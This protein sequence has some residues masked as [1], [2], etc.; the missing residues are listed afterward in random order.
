VGHCHIIFD[1][2]A[3]AFVLLLLVCDFD[4]KL[5]NSVWFIASRGVVGRERVGTAFPHLFHDFIKYCFKVSLTLFKMVSF[6][7]AFPHLFC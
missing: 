7:S 4:E 3:N 5:A 2:V 6:L 1:T